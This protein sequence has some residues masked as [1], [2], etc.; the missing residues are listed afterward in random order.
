VPSDCKT[1]GRTEPVK[2]SLALF[3]PGTL[4]LRDR[5]VS[6]CTG[7]EIR[8]MFLPPS[9]CKNENPVRVPPRAPYYRR[10]EAICP[11]RCVQNH[12]I[13]SHAGSFYAAGWL[14]RAGLA[15]VEWPLL[16]GLDRIFLT[17]VHSVPALSRRE[18]GSLIWRNFGFGRSEASGALD[19]VGVEAAFLRSSGAWF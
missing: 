8:R 1:Y 19:A 14:S 11:A 15:V 18:W 13:C 16:R 3:P 5:F 2:A 9:V 10:S 7:P 4:Y 12:G 17:A 6:V